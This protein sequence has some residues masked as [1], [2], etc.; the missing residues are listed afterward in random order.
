MLLVLMRISVMANVDIAGMAVTYIRS[1][2][3]HVPAIIIGPSTRARLERASIPQLLMPLMRSEDVQNMLKFA[4][5]L[6][7]V[8]C[9]D[10]CGQREVWAGVRGV[11]CSSTGLSKHGTGRALI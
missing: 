3:E 8:P 10:N 2:G 9:C 11:W 5:T 7:S 4:C 6:Y 1:T